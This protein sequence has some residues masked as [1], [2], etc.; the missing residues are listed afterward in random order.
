V[1]LPREELGDSESTLRCRTTLKR[2][3]LYSWTASGGFTFLP[4]DGEGLDGDTFHTH[5]NILTQRKLFG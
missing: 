4:E 5:S 2:S 1:H 3:D